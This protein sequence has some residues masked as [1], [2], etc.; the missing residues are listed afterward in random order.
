MELKQ[1]WEN[2]TKANSAIRKIK[3]A[4]KKGGVLDKKYS[5]FQNI[6]G[7]IDFRG[8]NAGKEKINGLKIDGADISYSNLSF[9][10][11][12]KSRFTNVLFKKVE[13]SGFSDKFNVFENCHFTNCKFQKSAIGYMGSKFLNCVFENCNFTDAVFIRAEFDNVKF[14]N[15]NLKG[16][17]FNASSFI[18]C[19]FEG[20]LEDV[21]FRG[22]Y[23][24]S[25]DI[26]EF[27]IARKNE[28]KDVSFEMA[29]MIGV[30][31]SND[32][33]LSSIKPPKEGTY[34]I[35]DKWHERLMRLK[36]DIEHWEEEEQIEANIFVNSYL[37]HAKNQ[38]WFLINAE[39]I[40]KEFGIIGDKILKR[41]KRKEA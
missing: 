41:I 8:I 16:V 37:V 26:N 2:D 28:M 40:N 4:F 14:V 25:S 35:F 17:D 3:K 34:M 18:S 21:W 1:R 9:S 39:E 13:F 22:S 38:D 5:P 33:D 19:S 29:T 12:N 15:S 30:N 10:F 20:H 23:E 7:Y 6:D 31:Y 27:G 11:I 24:I 32:C 36:L